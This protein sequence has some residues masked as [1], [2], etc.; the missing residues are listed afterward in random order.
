MSYRIREQ[1]G[2]VKDAGAAFYRETVMTVNPQDIELLEAYLD[3]ELSESEVR[4]LDER[5]AGDATLQRA[6]DRLRSHRE[7]RV[8]AMSAVFDTD[9]ASVDRLVAS[10]REAQQDEAMAKASQALA[11]RRKAHSPVRSI[12]AA[13][14]CVAFG[15]LLGVALQRQQT[16]SSLIAAPAVSS[17]SSFLGSPVDFQAHGAYVVSL[18]NQDGESVLSVHFQNQEQARQFMNR[19]ND[20]SAKGG[21]L[22]I[23]DAKLLEQPY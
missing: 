17:T 2:E 3:Q 16:S 5:L 9:S 1:G 20:P 11:V 13:A 10:V 21:P 12:F 4:S 15:L 22:H 23:G 7:L 8:A 18:V 19:V 14:A 6:L